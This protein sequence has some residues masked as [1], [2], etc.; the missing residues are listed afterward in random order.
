MALYVSFGPGLVPGP[1]GADTGGRRQG[2]LDPLRVP[3]AA[4]SMAQH[5]TGLGFRTKIQTGPKWVHKRDGELLIGPSG[6]K[7][8]RE[9][10]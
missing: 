9:A 1:I 4:R 6:A 2:G 8:Q 10:I 3:W 7:L 5:D